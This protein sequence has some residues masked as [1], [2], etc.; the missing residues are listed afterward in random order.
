MSPL[1]WFV[2]RYCG[3][4]PSPQVRFVTYGKRHKIVYQ[5]DRKRRECRR[6]STNPTSRDV[7]CL[8]KG[9]ACI[10]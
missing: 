4:Q 8:R 5:I 7:P 6:R 3:R 9:E 2:R 10:V 1:S